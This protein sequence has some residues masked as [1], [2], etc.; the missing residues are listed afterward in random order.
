M[1]V[2]SVCAMAGSAV[3]TR[4]ANPVTTV[5]EKRF[6]QALLRAKLVVARMRKDQSASSEDSMGPMVETQLAKWHLSQFS[7][8]ISTI[9]CV[10]TPESDSMRFCD[11]FLRRLAPLIA[12]AARG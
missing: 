12:T 9:A 4:T 8:D 6:I 7:C 1:T 5:I 10:C 2:T 11:P 3:V